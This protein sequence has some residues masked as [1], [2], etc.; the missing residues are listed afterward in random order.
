MLQYS[1]KINNMEWNPIESNLPSQ[2]DMISLAV[3]EGG[4]IKELSAGML[5]NQTAL[6]SI[7]IPQ[8]LAGKTAGGGGGDV[9]FTVD[10]E[11]VNLQYYTH[12]SPMEI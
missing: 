7:D 9:W 11:C 2:N 3:I 8:E 4:E 5:S 6:S 12:W 1:V 10:M